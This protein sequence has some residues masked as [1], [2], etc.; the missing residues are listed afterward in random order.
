SSSSMSSP[1][2]SPS[3]VSLANTPPPTHSRLGWESQPR[4]TARAFPV[5]KAAIAGGALLA[6]IMVWIIASRV[7]QPS[8]P[9]VTPAALTA[10][11][12]PVAAVAPTP[13]PPPVASI[14]VD[15][16]TPD[17]EAV[18]T[19]PTRSARD[20]ET[21]PVRKTRPA[22]SAVVNRAARTSPETAPPPAAKPERPTRVATVTPTETSRGSDAGVSEV[23]T[24]RPVAP[25]PPPPQTI[26]TPVATTTASPPAPAPVV[27]APVTP[28]VIAPA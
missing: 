8:A 2:V 28:A 26:T 4:P 12:P 3:G 22:A 24:H 11:P 7:S 19:A 1:D 21:A 14:P 13:P 23:E 20:Q 9:T 27:P 10:P 5:Q 6:G 16:S 25:P 15:A 18:A 17:A